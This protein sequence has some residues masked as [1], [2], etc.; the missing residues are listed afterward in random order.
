[1]HKYLESKEE[2][3]EYN[4]NIPGQ[5]ATKVALPSTYLN[6]KILIPEIHPQASFVDWP[7]ILRDYLYCID[8]PFPLKLEQQDHKMNNHHGLPF[9]EP[10]QIHLR[11][12][13]I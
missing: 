8:F 9:Q 11:K 7:S 1:M 6:F 12:F 3:C 13:G 4:T 2:K 5:P 10:H